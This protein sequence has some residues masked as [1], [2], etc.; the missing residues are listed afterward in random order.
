MKLGKQ[1]KQAL[2]AKGM[3]QSDLARKVGVSRM[4]VTNWIQGTRFPCYQNLLRIE[5]YL[6]TLRKHD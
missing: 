2:K 5:F 4:S 6:G 3:S 1:L